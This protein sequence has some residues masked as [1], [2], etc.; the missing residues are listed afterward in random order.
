LA[1]KVEEKSSSRFQFLTQENA[2]YPP[3]TLSKLIP[4]HEPFAP[5]EIVVNEDDGLMNVAP[6]V[7]FVQEA[8]KKMG[9][10]VYLKK[11]YSEAGITFPRLVFFHL[12][13]LNL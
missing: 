5:V 3:P 1:T 13:G 11:E 2:S 7:S 6:N 4:G 9:G 8:W 12:A 10:R